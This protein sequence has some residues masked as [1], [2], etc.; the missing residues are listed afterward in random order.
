MAHTTNIVVN[1]I[2]Y[3][4]IEFDHTAQEID[5][6]VDLMGGVRPNLLDNAI[7][8]GGGISGNLPINQRKK[9]SYNSTGNIIDRW[10]GSLPNAT[11][12]VSENYVT[13][14]KTSGTTQEDFRQT[15]SSDILALLKG[16]TATFS[17]LYTTNISGATAYVYFDDTFLG[18][19]KITLTSSS[20]KNLLSI[21]GIVPTD[22]SRILAFPAA[23]ASGSATVG[24]VN[25]IATK[26]EIGSKQTLGYK[27]NNND[28][29]LFPQPQSD[30]ATHLLKC[31]RYYKIYRTQSLRRKYA[32]DCCP[33]MR[34][35]PT[36]GTIVI[37]DVTYYYNS[38]EL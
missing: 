31:Q 4:V 29:R 23:F 25:V 18:G 6:A 13:L 16:K 24:N 15:I 27:D 20:K 34:I 26:L 21:T 14:S 5:D 1:G 17:I 22:A 8:I 10:T 28:W 2:S 11:F 32:E 38:A 9:T 37:N 30:Y 3:P 33:T 35:N 19:K 12:S 7:F 36:Q